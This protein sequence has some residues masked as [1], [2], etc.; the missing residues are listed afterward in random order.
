MKTHPRGH[1]EREEVCRWM[2]QEIGCT[3]DTC[4]YWGAGNRC[5][6]ERIMVRLNAAAARV[7]FGALGQK[8]EARTSEETMCQTFRPKNR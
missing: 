5:V 7:E 2:G 4:T 6:A 8:P 1:S 3:V